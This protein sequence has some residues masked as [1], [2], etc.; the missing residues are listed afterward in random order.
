MAIE[1][2]FWIDLGVAAVT[3]GAH[4]A[5]SGQAEPGELFLSVSTA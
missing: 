2:A 1:A 5:P 3:G 4:P